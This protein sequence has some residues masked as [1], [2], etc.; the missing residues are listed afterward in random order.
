MAKQ[1]RWAKILELCEKND[2]V[3]VQNLVDILHVSEA[4]IR[5][6]LQQME[7]LSL[8]S[9]FHGGVRTNNKGNNEPPMLY[10]AETNYEQKKMIARLAARQIKDNQ[11]I[12]ID[13]GS[14][15]L[16]MLKYITAKN[17]TVV[18]IGIPHIQKLI[19]R[20][21]RII[22]LGGTVRFT[23]EAITGN[24]TLQQLSE[25]YFD[26]TFL[27]VNG[28]HVKGG[29][30][31]TNDQEAAVKSKVIEHSQ[32]TFILADHSKFNRL[33][34][35]KFGNLDD[36]TVICYSIENFDSSLIKHICVK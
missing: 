17:I 33:Y 32:K 22:S 23:T 25:L 4:T 19:E 8:V 29:L 6:D 18:T 28:I 12:F 36:V 3:Y 9:R 2:A 20:K 13:A 5:R 34:P 11:M 15:T 27:G 35:V 31:T 21:I 1:Q 16:E 24:Q 14:S 26:I 7:D 30:T 10:K